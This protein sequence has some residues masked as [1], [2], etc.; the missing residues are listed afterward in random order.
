MSKNNSSTPASGVYAA[1]LT[2]R[3]PDSIEADTAAFL[4]YLDKV[5]SAHVDGLVFFGSTGEFVHFDLEQRMHVV[6]MG[7]RRSRVPVL[8]NVSHST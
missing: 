6:T 7:L 1:L 3:R 8:V 2:P 4:E 5:S